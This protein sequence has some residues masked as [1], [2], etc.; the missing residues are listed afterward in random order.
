MFWGCSKIINGIHRAAKVRLKNVSLA[1]YFGHVKC[2][3]RLYKKLA[4]FIVYTLGDTGFFRL[5]GIVKSTVSE[6]YKQ[7]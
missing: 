1:E 2:R 6:G 4:V 7:N 3:A 5:Q